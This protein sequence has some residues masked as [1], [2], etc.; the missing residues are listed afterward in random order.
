MDANKWFGHVEHIVAREIGRE[1]V[2]YVT[3]IYKYYVAFSQLVKE[4][5]A[6]RTARRDLEAASPASPLS[7]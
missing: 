5:D 6:R 7:P 4:N 3:N 1:T 2:Q